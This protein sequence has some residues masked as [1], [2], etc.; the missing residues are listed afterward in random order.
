VWLRQCWWHLWL[1]A[2]TSCSPT[3][4][5]ERSCSSGGLCMDDGA[6]SFHSVVLWYSRS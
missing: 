4:S 6:C 1:A 5:G 2:S 3:P